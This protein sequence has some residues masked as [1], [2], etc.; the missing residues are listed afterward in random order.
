MSYE[1]QT[2]YTYCATARCHLQHHLLGF[3]TTQLF[4]RCISKRRMGGLFLAIL[5]TWPEKIRLLLFAFN[6]MWQGFAKTY[7]V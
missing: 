2:E 3:K 4:V 6:L 7:H 1:S 5:S